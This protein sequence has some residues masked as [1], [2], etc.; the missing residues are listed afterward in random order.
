SAQIASQLRKFN[1]GLINLNAYADARVQSFQLVQDKPFGYSIGVSFDDG[2]INISPNYT[3]WPS[4]SGKE[5][6]TPLTASAMLKDTEI[7]PI[8][9]QFLKDHDISIANYGDPIVQQYAEAIAAASDGSSSETQTYVPDQMTV[10][11]PLKI[12]GTQV[13][14]DG[15]MPYG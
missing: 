6:Y 12:A 9:D 1:F 13:Y 4:L 14:E 3:Q 8:A 11:Y 15:A 5:P 10:V 2:S 7:I